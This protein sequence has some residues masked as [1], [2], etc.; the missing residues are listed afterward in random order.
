MSELTGAV[1]LAQLGKL[2]NLLA[3]M[4]SHKKRIKAQIS[5]LNGI[6]FR[7]L[8]DPAGDTAICL[9]FMLDDS[10]KVAGFAEALRAEGVNAAGVF[11]KGIPDWHIYSHWKHVI[12]K[13]TPTPEGCPYSCPHYKGDA[14]E[15]YSESMCPRTNEIL[16]RTIHI[17]IPAQLTDEDCDMIAKGI[18][19][20]ALA[21]L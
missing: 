18:R 20:V 16:A 12:G 10:S 19:K 6:T 11:D 3:L 17:D 5:G 9:M 21:L 13:A 4:R 7:P 15:K 8:N 2:D 14:P 1:M